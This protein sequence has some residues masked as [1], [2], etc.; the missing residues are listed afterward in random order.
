MSSGFFGSVR[1]AILDIN[2]DVE[3]FYKYRPSRGE[4]DIDFADFKKLDATECL[5]GTK[6]NDGE[7][8]ITIDLIILNIKNTHTYVKTTLEDFLKT[9]VKAS[10]THIVGMQ[11]NFL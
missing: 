11:K 6:A 1:P 7:S 2:N 3:I 4:T 5:V 9:V 8:K 10:F